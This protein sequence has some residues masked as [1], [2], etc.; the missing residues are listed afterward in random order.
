MSQFELNADE[1]AAMPSPLNDLAV[2]A[3]RSRAAFID[4]QATRLLSAGYSLDEMR[5]REHPDFRTELVVN[6]IVVATWQ[7]KFTD[8]N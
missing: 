6:D 8:I 4:E 5:L 2:E 3:A 7:M 1:L